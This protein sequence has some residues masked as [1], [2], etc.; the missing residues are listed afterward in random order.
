MA[1]RNSRFWFRFVAVVVGL[2]GLYVV[3]GLLLPKNWT[4]QQALTIH[5]GD[6]SAISAQLTD[7][8]KWPQWTVWNPRD[9]PGFQVEAVD[10]SGGRVTK[11]NWTSESLG[12]VSVELD[13]APAKSA[14]DHST[15]AYTMTFLDHDQ[16]EIRGQFDLNR[17]G[18][19]WQV[20]WRQQGSLASSIYARWTGLLVVR[21]LAQADMQAGLV[22]LRERIERRAN[23]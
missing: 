3:V 4:A 11:A 10:S 5:V 16:A 12:R 18:D 7:F 22:E 13:P 2:L 6:S 1:S 20:I 8:G 9:L 21:F 19:S 23:K 17:K 14:E 15:I